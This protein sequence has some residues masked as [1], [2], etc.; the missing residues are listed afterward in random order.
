MQLEKHYIALTVKDITVSKAFYEKLGFVQDQRW[1]GVEHKW[2]TM[3]H[4][5]IMIGLYQDMFPRNMLTFNPSDARSV[6][7]HVREQGLAIDMEANM[8]KEQGPCHF[9]I[10][11]PDGNP[12]LFDQHF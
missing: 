1:G 2:L 3:N 9:A 4:G 11:D 6:F 10:T 7:N 12:I 5:N 8:D